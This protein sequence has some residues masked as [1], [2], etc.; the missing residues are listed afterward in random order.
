VKIVVRK[1][2][3]DMNGPDYFAMLSEAEFIELG[4]VWEYACY[5]GNGVCFRAGAS[6]IKDEAKLRRYLESGMNRL[7]WEALHGTD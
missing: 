1:L 5:Y 3:K 2:D 4:Y 6:K 7:D